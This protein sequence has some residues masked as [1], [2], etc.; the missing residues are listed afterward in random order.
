MKTIQEIHEVL[1]RVIDGL[2]KGEMKP[3]QAVEIN[4]AV[5]KKIGLIKV[6]LEYNNI[7]GRMGD[8][9]QVIPLLEGES[10]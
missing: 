5:G 9:S 1:D 4:N 6:Q 8:K 7:R 2:E 10:K 3:P